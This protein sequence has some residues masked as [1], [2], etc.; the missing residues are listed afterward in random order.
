MALSEVSVLGNIPEE[1]E[2]RSVQRKKA[3]IGR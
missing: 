1:Q 3:A 2:K